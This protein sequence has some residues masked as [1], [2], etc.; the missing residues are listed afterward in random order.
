MYMAPEIWKTKETKVIGYDAMPTD[1]F[2]LG[3]TLF[4]MVYGRMPFR[5]GVE[6]D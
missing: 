3:V 1:V 4:A 6:D 5:R 2:A